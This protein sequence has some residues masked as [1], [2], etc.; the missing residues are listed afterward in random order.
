[1]SNSTLLGSEPHD[2]IGGSDRRAFLRGAAG[3][4]GGAAVASVLHGQSQPSVSVST[5]MF[6]GFKT[7]KVQTTGAT[8]NVVSG[9]QGSP[10]LLLHGNPETHVMWHKIALQTAREF[11]VVAADLRGYGDSSKPPDGENHSNYSNRNM[12]LDQIEVMNHLGF[13]KFAVVGTTVVGTTVVGALGTDWPW[14]TLTE[15]QN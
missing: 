12:A 1:M 5:R 8:I 14:T 15:S 7:S 11:T 13:E 3:V 2:G 10:V 9:G 4:L 6:D